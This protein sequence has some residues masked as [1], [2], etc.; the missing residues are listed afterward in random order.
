MARIC[1]PCLG[2]DITIAVPSRE[3]SFSFKG[4]DNGVIRIN[5]ANALQAALNKGNQRASLLWRGRYLDV[6]AP[7]RFYHAVREVVCRSFRWV[8]RAKRLEV[9]FN[10]AQIGF[11]SVK[12]C[13]A[14]LTPLPLPTMARGTVFQA[15]CKYL[16]SSLEGAS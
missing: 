15:Y 8:P 12:G 9:F 1:P 5:D 4:R 16:R 6:D 10:D 14:N 13:K 7:P 2:F 3:G 11:R